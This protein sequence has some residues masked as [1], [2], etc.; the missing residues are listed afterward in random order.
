MGARLFI[1][2]PK[3]PIGKCL[4]ILWPFG[5]FY[6]HRLGIFSDHLVHI[7]YIWYIFSGF[8]IPYQEKSGNPGAEFRRQ[9][10]KNVEK[11]SEQRRQRLSTL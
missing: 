4:Y 11:M 5:T 7:V 2:K 3:I 10:E 8:G 9:A 1:F 6:V